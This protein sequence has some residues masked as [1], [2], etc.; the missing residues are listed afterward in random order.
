[1]VKKA[2]LKV[3]VIKQKIKI[4]EIKPEKEENIEDIV[5]D[6]PSRIH[7][8]HDINVPVLEMEHVPQLRK[9]LPQSNLPKQPEQGIVTYETRKIDIENIEKRYVSE[10]TAPVLRKESELNFA[11]PMP[12]LQQGIGRE[13]PEIKEKYELAKPREKPKPKYPWET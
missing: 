12:I 2:K 9:E 10:R 7:S 1:M 13:E 4:K 3:K 5:E 6:T 11:K 8:P